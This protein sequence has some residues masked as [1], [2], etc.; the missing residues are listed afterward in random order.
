[1]EIPE[2]IPPTACSPRTRPDFDQLYSLAFPLVARFVAKMGGNFDDA[3]DIFQDALVIFHEKHEDPRFHIRVPHQA[4]LLG[5]AK[6]LW[7]ARFKE[8]RAYVML[9]ETE[10]TISIPD[11]F[12]P[13]VNELRV[14]KLLERSGQ[15]CL[16]LLRAFYYEKLPVKQ[17]ARR[18]GY[19]TEHSASV[20]KYKCIEK[21]RTTLKQHAVS[22]ED[23]ID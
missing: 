7:I 4:Y 12:H 17:I 15:K 16:S 9:D 21:I 2:L 11:R 6:H 20:Q 1:M 13:S 8:A 3:R 22:Y 5:I 10:N 14:L 19:A 23:F 18:L